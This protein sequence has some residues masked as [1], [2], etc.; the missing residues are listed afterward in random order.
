M[1]KKRLFNLIKK[2]EGTKVDYKQKIDLE[3][4]SSRKELAKDICAIANSKG[5]RGYL[6]IGIEDKTK[7]IVGIEGKKYS[8]EQLQQ[9]VS[10]R[11]EPPIPVSLEFINFDNKELAVI[12]I[13][14][15]PQKPYQSREN[16]AF[17]IRRGSTTDTMRKEEIISALQENLNLNLELCPIVKSD[18]SCVNMKLVHKYF[19]L[20]GIDVDDNNII[21]F[22]ENASIITFDKDSNRYMVT[23]GGL[24]VFSDINSL[25]VPHNMI[26]IIN[27]INKNFKENI[28]I[29]GN[30][31]SMLDN[32]EDILKK[33]LP[34]TYPVNG[35][36]EGLRNAVL[37]RD[38][39][40]YYKEI[41][42][43]LNYN[44][45]M[46]ISPGALMNG[47]N[48]NSS[49][50]LKRNM[51]IYEKLIT[52]D[53]EERFVNTGRGFFR[54]KR[55]FKGKGRLTF[56]NSIKENSFKIIYPGI[57]LFK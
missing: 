45:I 10:S 7:K 50:Y 53:S 33:I 47:K 52:M 54:M 22:A 57:S 44:S 32:C 16:G 1:D 46:L 2:G 40:L 24:L 29:Q 43:I 51:W 38:Y 26:R 15:G 31:L 4:E 3:M 30:L 55:Y 25:Y 5:G 49:Q 37:Y 8:E 18:M 42:I 11:C 12:N 20:K 6:I 48:L 34:K 17:Y 9:I 36:F 21:S 56:V 35:I 28:I 39:T 14:D 13:Y 41:E 27:K 23:L 19:N